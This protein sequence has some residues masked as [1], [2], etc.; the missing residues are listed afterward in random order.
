MSD[1]PRAWA[2]AELT[3]SGFEKPANCTCRYPE[4]ICRN[5]NGHAPDCPV[6]IEW[7][8]SFDAEAEAGQGEGRILISMKNGH[9]IDAL[10]I[11][12]NSPKSQKP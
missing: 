12:V 4:I 3:Q 6:Y 10:A 5:M 9:V 2:K 7:A 1:K 11:G 8:K